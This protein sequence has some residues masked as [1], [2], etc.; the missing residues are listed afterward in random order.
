M[1]SAPTASRSLFD[2]PD[3]RLDEHPEKP[4][5]ERDDDRSKG[6]GIDARSDLFAGQ[7]LD[8]YRPPESEALGL[9]RLRASD[10]GL[11]EIVFV[12]EAD[13]SETPRPNALT[14]R[15]RAQL[16]EYFDGLRQ[17][18]D[19][20]LAPKG[21]DFQQRVWQAL[22]TIPFGETRCYAEI[23]EQLRCKGGQRA[24]GR[25]NGQNPLAIVVPCHRVIGS[26][27]RMT[28]YAGGIGRKQWLLAHE[29]G[30]IPFD[31]G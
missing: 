23:A 15:A 13:A 9:V 3:A 26:D 7:A 11:T 18:F 2:Q 1:S 28:G 14:D 8:Y 4:S 31:L 20:P 10:T 17:T 21:T 12:T 25:A 27:G 5:D 19:L 6:Q 30:E 29:A 16:E 22:A 24:V